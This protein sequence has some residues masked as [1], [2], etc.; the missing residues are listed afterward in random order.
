MKILVVAD[1]ESPYIWDYFD[2]S[3]FEDI[4]LVISCGDL[5]ASYLSFIVTMLPVP[6][7][8]VPGNHDK[9]YVDNPPE[10]CI[11]IDD[12]IFEYRGIRF[13]GLGGCMEYTGGTYQY[14]EKQM[15]KRVKKLLKATKKKGD[16][17]VLVTHAPTFQ[18]GDG[19]DRCH[20]G[21][22]SFFQIYNKNTLRFH[23]HG[24]QHLNYS[25]KA[26]RFHSYNDIQI[27]NG[28]NYYILEI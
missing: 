6:L 10:G 1:Q 7:I 24:H 18:I 11:C 8:Y 3:K 9:K 5:K 16:I 15:C 25:P 2:K 27:I 17:D 12:E 14:S 20:T 4:E 13:A 23:F 19:E 28:F 22:E 21:F 26:S